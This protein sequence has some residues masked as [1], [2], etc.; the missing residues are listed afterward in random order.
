MK[1][2]NITSII[3]YTNTLKWRKS[4]QTFNAICIYIAH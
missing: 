2:I 1:Y 4:R 3:L